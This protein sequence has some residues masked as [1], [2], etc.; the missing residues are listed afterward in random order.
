[1]KVVGYI[2]AGVAVSFAGSIL[3]M[4]AVTAIVS[5]KFAQAFGG[6]GVE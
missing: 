4:W 3:A 2:L 5:R 1:M 6:G